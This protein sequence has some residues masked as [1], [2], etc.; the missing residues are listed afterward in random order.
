MPSLFCRRLT[1]EG[2]NVRKSDVEAFGVFLVWS[3]NSDT[4]ERFPLVDS[5]QIALSVRWSAYPLLP[6]N[7]VRRRS[8][9]PASRANSACFLYCYH[10]ALNFGISPLRST[11]C[12][13]DERETNPGNCSEHGRASHHPRNGPSLQK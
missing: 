9:H 1:P 3:S 10:R 6:H 2:V 5:L 8:S 13:S 12:T 4:N 7:N 11:L